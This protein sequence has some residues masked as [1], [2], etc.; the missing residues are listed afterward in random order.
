M[1]KKTSRT[2]IKHIDFVFWDLLLLAVVYFAVFF[3][4]FYKDISDERLSAFVGEGIIIIIVYFVAAIV[5]NLYKD[6]LSRNKW[7]EAAKVFVQMVI[8]YGIGIIFL[9]IFHRS[10]DSSRLFIGISAVI[11][12]VVILFEHL[13]WKNIIRKRL[14]N[15]PRLPHLLIVA[16]SDRVRRCTSEILSRRFNPF[17]VAGIVVSDFD[18]AGKT[19]NGFPVVC[20]MEEIKDY[21]LHEIIDEVFIDINDNKAINELAGICLATGIAVHINYSGN[22]TGFPNVTPEEIGGHMVLTTS[23]SVITPGQLFAKRLLDIAIGFFGVLA[24]LAAYLFVAPK[25]KAKD[26]GPVFFHQT[27]IGKNGRKFEL[28]KFRSMYMDAEARKAELMARN[29]MQGLMF[30]MENDPRILPGIGEKIRR[31]SIDEFPQFWNVLKGDMS[32]IGIRPPT[33]SEY[34]QY[35]AHHKARLSFKPGLTGLWQVSGRNDITDFEEIVRLD[36]EYI[37]N[38]SLKEDFIIFL[39]TIDVV[40]HKKGS[41]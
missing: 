13:V 1:Y 32:L 38:W 30:K 20:S 19:V 26:P 33:V 6:I 14:Y 23:N 2:W 37:K 17:Y 35:E 16:D 29:E 12:F 41:M 22:I 3:I 25:I 9:F 8:T 36:T 24:M 28:Y 15:N 21:M 10:D 5:G 4:G 7:I 34:E 27:R 31:L 18:A 40:L 11:S 39:K